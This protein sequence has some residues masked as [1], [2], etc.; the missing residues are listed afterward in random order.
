MLTRDKNFTN[1]D[2]VFKPTRPD[3]ADF[4]VDVEDSFRWA[5]ILERVAVPV[6]IV[7]VRYVFRSEEN[8]DVDP[9]VLAE[10]DEKAFFAAEGAGGLI[11]YEPYDGL[12]YCFWESVEQAE[13]ATSGIEHREA[14]KYAA[15]AYKTWSLLR[16][17][18]A[19]TTEGGIVFFDID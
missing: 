9:K 5:D 19:R 17:R 2:E 10:L 1:T 11:L 7:V 14:A 3:Y 6:G 15:I 4:D 8:P 13:A 12:S 18:I 16:H